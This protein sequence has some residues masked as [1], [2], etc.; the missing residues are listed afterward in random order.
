MKVFLNILWYFPFFG[1]IFAILTAI[2]GLFWCLTVVGLPLGLGLLQ[3][4]K[5]LFAPHT[6]ELVSQKDLSAAKGEE[7]NKVWVVFSTIVRILYFPFGLILAFFYVIIAA[8]NFISIIGIPNGL[9]YVKMIP[10]VFNPIGKVCV[11]GAIA[12]KI[13]ADKDQAKVDKYFGTAN[14]AD[15]VN[16]SPSNNQIAKND[17]DALPKTDNPRFFEDDKIAD[18]LNHPMMY[19]DSLVEECKKEKDIRDNMASVMPEVE[20]MPMEKIFEIVNSSDTYSPVIERCAQVVFDKENERLVAERA[21]QQRK[22]EEARRAAREAEKQR[23][24]ELLLKAL[25]F[26]KKWKYVIGA[27]VIVI[28]AIWYLLWVTSDSHRFDV[29]AEASMDGDYEKVIEYTLKIDNPDSKYYQPALILGLNAEKYGYELSDKAKTGSAILQQRLDDY[30]DNTTFDDYNFIAHHYHWQQAF[31]KIDKS[32]INYDSIKG[33]E[34]SDEWLSIA[35]AYENSQVSA[36]MK[37]EVTFVAAYAYFMHKDYDAAATLFEQIRDEQYGG[38]D[39]YASSYLGIINLFKLNSNPCSRKDAFAMLRE[40]ANDGL[41]AFY[42]G[43]GELADTDEN[44]EKRL[45]NARAS[46]WNATVPVGS[47][48]VDLIDLCR[49]TVGSLIENSVWNRYGYTYSN[50]YGSGRYRGQ[51]KQYGW[52]QQPGGWGVFTGKDSYCN[53]GKFYFENDNVYRSTGIEI[54]LKGDFIM[55]W[56]YN[57]SHYSESPGRIN[58]SE[59]QS[60]RNALNYSLNL[61]DLYSFNLSP[62][63]NTKKYE[64]LMKRIEQEECMD[65]YEE[66]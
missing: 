8:L 28:A 30:V 62:I 23:I 58:P 12:R 52:T 32:I 17:A 4:A 40:G 31:D 13:K 33:Y 48:Y 43:C 3:I 18:V 11:G 6:F 16:N 46:L 35:L 38:M 65:D 19:R 24:K 54:W 2:N 45:E 56:T 25:E 57:S 44:L 50:S 29:A 42:K 20:A 66:D 55:D 1:F 7:R 49:N 63:Q 37:H 26:V 47:Y 61:L 64:K 5:F 41:L 27:G 36:L 59:F 39:Q 10:A 60:N 53:Y 51:T 15:T 14:T 9:V 34:V 22:E 21:E